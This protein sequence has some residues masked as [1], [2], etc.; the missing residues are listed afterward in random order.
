MLP[1]NLTTSSVMDREA[2]MNIKRSGA[3]S[4]AG[5]ILLFHSPNVIGAPSERASRERAGAV[6]RPSR[7]RA[8]PER[9]ARERAEPSYRVREAPSGRESTEVLGRRGGGMVVHPGRDSPVT[10][11]RS[12]GRIGL[13][14]S[15]GSEVERMSNTRRPLDINP[16]NSRIIV[17]KPKPRIPF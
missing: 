6:E 15:R 13:D 8:T 12:P 3:W 5:V 9:P 11:S 1:S 14:Y 4:A 17:D 16:D 2:S 7:E 10:E